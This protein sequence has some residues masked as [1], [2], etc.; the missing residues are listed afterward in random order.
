MS[1]AES[2]AYA[3]GYAAGRRKRKSDLRMQQWEREQQ[4]FLDKAFVAAL[5]FCLTAEG[6][7]YKGR[8]ISGEQDRID[9]AWRVAQA[10]LRRRVNL[11]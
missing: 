4:A 11:V 6:W 3:K 2:R 9:F 7:T 8:P 10:A 5:P 1:D